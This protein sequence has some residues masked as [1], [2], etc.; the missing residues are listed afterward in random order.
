MTVTETVFDD[1]PMDVWPALRVFAGQLVGA[2]PFG[3]EPRE[4]ECPR[5]SEVVVQDEVGLA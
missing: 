2:Q 1:S 3:V 4:V 5:R